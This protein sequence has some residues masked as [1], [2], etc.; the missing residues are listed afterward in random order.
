MKIVQTVQNLHGLFEEE[1]LTRELPENLDRII[2]LAIR[3]DARGSMANE[4]TPLAAAERPL[5][6]PS[7]L[8]VV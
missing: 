8:S 1:L 2:A 6:L 3:I 4:A 7:V 5:W